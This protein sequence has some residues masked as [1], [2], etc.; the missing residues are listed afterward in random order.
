MSAYI[1]KPWLLPCNQVNN[2][3]SKWV[4]KSSTICTDETT[5][6]WSKPV[7]N[8]ALFYDFFAVVF[9][10]EL[11]F[12]TALLRQ[13]F[14]FLWPSDQ[15]EL[16]GLYSEIL[17]I[18]LTTGLLE[19]QIHHIFWLLN[20]NSFKTLES[21]SIFVAWN[22]N[23]FHFLAYCFG[24]SLHDNYSFISQLTVLVCHSMTKLSDT[25]MI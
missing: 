7:C 24:L 21:K 4:L 20:P 8:F 9:N 25:V 18:W 16:S 22:P 12:T 6:S 17:K 23:R 15:G 1:L 3:K 19:I 10:H 2:Y 13:M 14:H 5:A 11:Y